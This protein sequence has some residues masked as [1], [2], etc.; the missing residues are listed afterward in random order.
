MFSTLLGG[1]QFIGNGFIGYQRGGSMTH[2]LGLFVDL[3]GLIRF[4][5]FL[6]GDFCT[7][8]GFMLLNCVGPYFFQSGLMRGFTFSECNRLHVSFSR[9]GAHGLYQY[10]M[11]AL[12]GVE[13]CL[14][15]LPSFLGF[16][17]VFLC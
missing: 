14:L 3:D 13:S 8:R 7:I 17:N 12:L 9:I 16:Y 6:Q 15:G 5:L 2:F 11:L 4:F 10:S 1:L